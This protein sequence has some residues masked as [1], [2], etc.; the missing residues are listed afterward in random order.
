MTVNC[1]KCNKDFTPTYNVLRNFT[2]RK[3]SFGIWCEGCKETF[4]TVGD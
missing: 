2:G 4:D 3:G 1:P